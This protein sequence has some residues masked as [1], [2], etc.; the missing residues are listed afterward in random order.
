MA[1]DNVGSD[2]V[3]NRCIQNSRIRG[4]ETRKG[5]TPGENERNLCWKTLELYDPSTQDPLE[6][7]RTCSGANFNRQGDITPHYIGGS[8]VDVKWH[9]F[10]VNDE[11]I[12]RKRIQST[13]V[14]S[15]M[16]FLVNG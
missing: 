16:P 6:T 7:V 10:A 8:H 13:N 1:H 5:D 4:T 9:Y 14:I 11:F 12:P 2:Y 15:M 3:H